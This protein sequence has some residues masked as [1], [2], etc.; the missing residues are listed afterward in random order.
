M[1]TERTGKSPIFL[2]VTVG[3]DS[4]KI[5]KYNKLI[6]LIARSIANAFSQRSI[7]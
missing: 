1:R 7:N 2:T 6:Q 4:D 5:K 3:R